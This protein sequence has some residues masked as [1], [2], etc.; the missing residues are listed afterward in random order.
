[1][2]GQDFKSWKARIHGVLVLESFATL[3]LQ[4]RRTQLN[5]QS[6]QLLESQVG[7]DCIHSMCIYSR[8]PGPTI[9]ARIVVNRDRIIHIH[10]SYGGWIDCKH[11]YVCTVHTY[12]GGARHGEKHWCTIVSL[13]SLSRHLTLYV[14]LCIV[15]LLLS[16]LKKSICQLDAQTIQYF[17]GLL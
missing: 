11:K 9:T 14:V 15:V 1:V 10:S 3:G 2:F 16:C 12:G 7:C 5:L 8:D 6:K 13:F 4:K 17:N